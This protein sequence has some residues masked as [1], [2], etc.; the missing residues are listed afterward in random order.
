MWM[1]AGL[2]R[3]AEEG[4][5]AAISLENL[6]GVRQVWSLDGDALVELSRI[7]AGEDELAVGAVGANWTWA[8]AICWRLRAVDDWAVV[9]VDLS[10]VSATNQASPWVGS[11]QNAVPGREWAC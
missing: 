3:V 5:A 11:D 8:R 7:G 2:F 1:N 6:E 9:Q 4:L 10:A